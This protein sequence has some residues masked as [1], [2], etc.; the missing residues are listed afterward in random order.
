MP[1]PVP[2]DDDVRRVVSDAPRDFERPQLGTLK[3]QDPTPSSVAPARSTMKGTVLGQAMT[4]DDWRRA[5]IFREILDVPISL[6][7]E[8]EPL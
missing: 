5:I 6:R 3:Q 1:T 7:D 8:G 4:A 2:V